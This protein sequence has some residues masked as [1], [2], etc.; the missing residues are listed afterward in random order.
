[1]GQLDAARID[2]AA[3]HDLARGYDTVADTVTAA[4]SHLTG[5]AF[6]G[7]VAGR[8]HAARGDALRQAIDGIDAMM[9]RWADT[10]AETAAALRASAG[11]YV[12]TDADAARRL[13]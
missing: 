8:S 10:A 9:V 6:D 2:V 1:M 4:R 7:T 3:L 12:C 11:D 13:V 5:L